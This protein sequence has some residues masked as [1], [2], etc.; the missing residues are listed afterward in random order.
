MEK[1]V[2]IYDLNDPQQYEDERK[3]WAGKT[4]EERLSAL[5]S[6]RRTGEKLGLYKEYYNG[7]KQRLLRVLRVVE[8]K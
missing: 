1:E 4:P 7:D 6:I 8:R 3:Y 2:R 5:E